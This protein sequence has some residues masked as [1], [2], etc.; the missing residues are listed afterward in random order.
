MQLAGQVASW[1]IQTQTA[2]H[3]IRSK[4]R[5]FL[6]QSTCETDNATMRAIKA[7]LDPLGMLNRGKIFSRT[8]EQ[9][10][11]DS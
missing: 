9:R 1:A 6:S 5:A 8:P 2:E 3:S 7:A 10:Y 11:E 4:K